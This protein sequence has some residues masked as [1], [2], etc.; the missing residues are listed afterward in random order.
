MNAPL[1][2]ILF[3]VSQRNLE[4]NFH[5]KGQLIDIT[6][7]DASNSFFNKSHFKSSTTSASDEIQS[8]NTM[9]VKRRE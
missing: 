1:A 4:K 8:F 5:L 7:A 9:A 6:Q 3:T 2:E